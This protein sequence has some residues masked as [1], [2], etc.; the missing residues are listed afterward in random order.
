M[1]LIPGSVSLFTALDMSVVVGAQDN[2]ADYPG[3]MMLETSVQYA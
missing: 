1:V 3:Q 2:L